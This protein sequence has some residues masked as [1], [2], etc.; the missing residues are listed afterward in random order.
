[1]MITNNNNFIKIILIKFNYIWFFKNISVF[2]AYKY[3]IL[4]TMSFNI[5]FLCTNSISPLFLS[6][7]MFVFN[8]TYMAFYNNKGT[9]M[10]NCSFSK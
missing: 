2:N 9:D 10:L 1:M 3:R 5:N 4:H 8:T 6:V 7:F